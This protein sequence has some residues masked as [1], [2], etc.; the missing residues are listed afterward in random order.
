MTST[1]PDPANWF[2]PSLPRSHQPIP[3]GSSPRL[4]RDFFDAM[5]DTASRRPATLPR[6]VSIHQDPLHNVNRALEN[7]NRALQD[8]QEAFQQARRLRTESEARLR[9]DSE[10]PGQL[11]DLTATSSPPA[12]FDSPGAAE[13]HYISH[14]THPHDPS[15]THRSRTFSSLHEPVYPP[16]DTPWVASDND[17]SLSYPRTNVRF[18]PPYRPGNVRLP[19]IPHLDSGQLQ[20]VEEDAITRQRQNHSNW[21]RTQAR[22]RERHRHQEQDQSQPNSQSSP[23]TATMS[24]PASSSSR[25]MRTKAS[26]RRAP[27]PELLNDPSVDE[28]D[29]TAVDDPASLSAAL[30]KQREEAILAQNPGTEEGRTPFTAYKC[31]VCMDT[32]TNATST[33]CGHVFCHR[34]IVDTLNWSMEQRREAHP[35]NRKLKGVCPVCRKPLDLKDTP[36]TGRSLVPLELK[37][38]VRKRK[39]E[40]APDNGKG[41][42]KLL[43]KAETL[44][45][46]EDDGDVRRGTGRTRKRERESTEDA[47]WRTFTNDAV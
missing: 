34:C 3:R 19:R 13:S 40:Q 29:L 31:P 46:D 33:S 14:T 2:P 27:S 35:G 39:R 24:P 7:A 42:G 43:V 1:S 5:P 6:P 32:P 45:D 25:T 17:P 4:F 28:V 47:I 10:A 38:M 11:V 23:T 22:N 12:A 36:G 26:L 30:S 44:S 21:Q 18:F 20:S 16:S 15:H 41:K 37:L 9:T 8:A